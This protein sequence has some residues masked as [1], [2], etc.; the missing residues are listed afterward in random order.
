VVIALSV[1]AHNF[2]ELSGP[3]ASEHM[4][5]VYLMLPFLGCVLALAYFNAFPSDVF[6]GDS[7]TYFAG[8]ALAVAA[9]QAH[10]SKTLMLFFLPQLL[11]FFLSIPQLIGIV[12]CPRH[13]LPIYNK[14]TKLLSY[15]RNF[16]L[17]NATLYLTGPMSEKNL[18]RLLTAFHILCCFIGFAIRYSHTV[19]TAFYESSHL[20]SC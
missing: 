13:R 4:N 10:F 16:T 5:S 2:V 14:E 1:L 9:I 17:I 7:F 3:C 11:N 6:V 20:L 18:N 8:M 12:H 19:T 15:S